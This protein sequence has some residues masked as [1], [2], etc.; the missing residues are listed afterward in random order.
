MHHHRIWILGLALAA[1]VAGIGCGDTDETAASSEE[2]ISEWNGQ[3]PHIVPKPVFDFLSENQWGDHHLVFHMSR[4]YFVGGDGVR[5]WLESQHEKYAELQEGDADNGVEFL[6]MHQAM[7]ERLREKFGSV[8]TSGDTGFKTFGKVL[9]GWNTDAKLLAAIDKYGNGYG[10]AQLQAALPAVNDFASFETEDEFG[11]FLQTTL[12]ISYEVDPNDSFKRFYTRD[13]RA[14][15]G[16]HN[17][18]HGM[19]ADQSSPVDV[20]DPQTNLGNQLFWGIHGWIEAKWL[21]FQKVHVRTAEEQR[22]YDDHL[23]RFRLMMQLFDAGFHRHAPVPRDAVRAFSSDAF[24]D[25]IP[26]ENLDAS[27]GMEGCAE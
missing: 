2:N 14:G 20:G 24:N 17:S 10:K 4:R 5:S 18:L 21:A 27:T 12:R 25:E 13:T 8:K 23:E 15:A 19:F 11:L 1:S 6:A 22:L 9:D 16:I 3:V 7:I 26:C